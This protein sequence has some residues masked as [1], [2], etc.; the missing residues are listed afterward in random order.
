[1]KKRVVA[2]FLAASARTRSSVPGCASAC[3]ANAALCGWSP[4]KRASCA[5]LTSAAAR[6]ATRAR[7]RQRLLEQFTGSH[8]VAR[9]EAVAGCRHRPAVSV[10]RLVERRQPAGLLA[11]LRGCRG[12]APCAGVLRRLLERARD[13]GVGDVRRKREVA[14]ALVRVRDDVR[15]APVELA[16]P[17]RV[18]ALVG[19]RGEQRVGEADAV[20]LEL[21]DLRL[22]RR[23]EGRLAVGDFGG[24]KP[25]RRLR[26]RGCRGQDVATLRRQRSEPDANELLEAVGHR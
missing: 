4:S 26:Q 8:R 12:R 10:V 11:Q 24:E 5:R 7:R 6:R 13:V 15:E 20:A 16:A 14:G 17:D 19:P 23:A 18:E 22:E 1:M 25:E 21:D 9:D 3:R 2:R